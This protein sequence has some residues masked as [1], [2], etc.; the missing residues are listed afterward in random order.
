LRKLANSNLRLDCKN[1]GKK[2]TQNHL[3]AQGF[4]KLITNYINQAFEGNRILAE[5]HFE[6]VLIQNCPDL[7]SMFQSQELRHSFQLLLPVAFLLVSHS[8]IAEKNI[9]LFQ[10]WILSKAEES[11]VPFIEL[12]Q[13]MEKYFDTVEK[14]MH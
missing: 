13:K 11:E 4:G 14:A 2:A 6:N 9:S 10:K 3:D 1:P 12:S 5:A 8:G 7:N